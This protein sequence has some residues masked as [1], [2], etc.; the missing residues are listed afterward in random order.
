MH[1][2]HGCLFQSRVT[3][4]AIFKVTAFIIVIC[5]A[6]ICLLTIIVTQLIYW[7]VEDVTAMCSGLTFYSAFFCSVVALIVVVFALIIGMFYVFFLFAKGEELLYLRSI[8]K[9]T[10]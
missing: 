5:D 6:F 10:V 8:N 3:I 9:Y 2:A 1:S 4:S 7:T